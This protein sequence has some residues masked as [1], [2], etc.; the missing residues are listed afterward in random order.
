MKIRCYNFQ[1]KHNSTSRP[2]GA[3]AIEFEVALKRNTSINNPIFL[4]D[5]GESYFTYN[6]IYWVEMDTYYYVDDVVYGNEW[7]KEVVCSCDVLAIA[8]QYIINST[9]FVKYSSINFD[10][11]INDDRIKPTSAIETLI[12]NNSFAGL[13]AKPSNAATYCYIL[14]TLNSNGVTSYVVSRNSLNYIGAALMD[15][16]EDI[17]GVLKEFFTS[18]KDSIL[19]IQCIPWSLS[20]LQGQGIVGSISEY[21]EIGAYSTTIEGY[22]IDSSGILVSTDFVDIPTRPNDFTRIE[23][24][25]EGKIHLPLLGT[26]DLSLSELQDVNRLYFR[27]VSNVLTGDTTCIL[28]KG[29]ADINQGKVFASTAGNVNF[30]IPLG[31]IT[32]SNPTG[33]IT[34]VGGVGAAVLATTPAGVVGG[35]AAAVASFASYFSKT[36]SS[37][38]AFGGNSSAYDSE[39]LQV[40]IY[41]HGLTESPDNLRVLHGR[42][43]GK[44][45][46][47]STLVN[48]Y[49]QTSE[50][51]LQA[52]FDDEMTQQVNRLMDSG[53]YLY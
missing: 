38:G 16:A 6:Y 9:A 41:K 23:P 26:M 4:L 34:G 2:T 47:L 29:N 32:Q 36:S 15:H 22:R 10:P 20:A 46:N 17:I 25:C 43:C 8:R 50:F 49:V 44:V 42:P 51:E 3:V 24:Y 40:I 35:I 45:L 1:K 33:F 5:I 53:V 52:G 18:A 28:Y 7:I 21:I 13:I 27:Y 30:E 37:V 39:K 19:K 31:Y 14:T 12:S 48:G 11:Y